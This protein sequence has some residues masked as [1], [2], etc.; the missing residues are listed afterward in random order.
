MLKDVLNEQFNQNVL[1]DVCLMFKL[2]ELDSNSL[3]PLKVQVKK[4]LKKKIRSDNSAA[5]LNEWQ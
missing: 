3:W 4:Y 5:Q 1:P 2:L